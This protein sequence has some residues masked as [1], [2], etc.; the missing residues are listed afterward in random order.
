[1]VPSPQRVGPVS[2]T[3]RRGPAAGDPDPEERQHARGGRHPDGHR[4]APDP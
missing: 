1:L 4:H 3:E 2:Q